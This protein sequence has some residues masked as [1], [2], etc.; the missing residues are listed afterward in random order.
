MSPWQMFHFEQFKMWTSVSA[1]YIQIERER[2][3]ERE[4]EKERERESS[5]KR[6]LKCDS[7]GFVQR[8]V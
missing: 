1:S 5:E 4:R 6:Q 3:R 2:E 7:L 8:C